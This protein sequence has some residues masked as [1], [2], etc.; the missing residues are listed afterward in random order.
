M[1]VK[2]AQYRPV[3]GEH[4][5]WYEELGLFKQNILSR[6]IDRSLFF[7]LFLQNLFIR[8]GNHLLLKAGYVLGLPTTF[9]ITGRRRL[10]RS[11][12]G[13]AVGY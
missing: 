1:A 12:A 10:G 13:I 2:G 4:I 8:I 3:T 9:G 11:S 7:S 6:L 5:E